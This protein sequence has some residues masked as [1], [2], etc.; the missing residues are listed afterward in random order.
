MT[1]AFDPTTVVT[2]DSAGFPSS[3]LGDIQ[4]SEGVA[5]RLVQAAAGITSPAG[6]ILVTA[7]TAGVPTWAVNTTTTASDVLVAGVVPAGLTATIASG[8]YFYLQVSGP[9]DMLAS[10]TTTGGAIGTSTV[11]GSGLPTGASSAGQ[12]GVNLAAATAANGTSKV[13]LRGLI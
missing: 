8:S 12:C 5:Y 11:A 1:L 4:I 9:A 6:K 3:D 13:L 7:A 10:V 2:A